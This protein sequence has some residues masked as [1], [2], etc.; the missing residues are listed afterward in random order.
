MRNMIEMGV[1]LGSFE[2]FVAL[3]K[4]GTAQAVDQ[5]MQVLV[6][7]DD[8]GTSKLVDYALSLVNQSAGVAQIRHYLFHGNPQQ[9]NFAALYFKRRGQEDLLS[10]AVALGRIDLHQAFSK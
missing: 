1:W 5:L 3:G 10:E 2:D 8:L 6:S 4:S 7:R 9:R